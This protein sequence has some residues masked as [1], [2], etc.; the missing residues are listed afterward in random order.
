MRAEVTKRTR[1]AEESGSM[2]I[3]LMA[4]IVAAGLMV[5][6]T[7]YALS[8]HRTVRFDRNRNTVIQTADA[9]INQVLF[10]L[11]S[12]QSVPTTGSFSAW[13]PVSGPNGAACTSL[14]QDNCFRWRAEPWPNASGTD[15][16]ITSEGTLNGVT[17]RVQAVLNRPQP[18]RYGVFADN[19]LT[20]N[21]GN[22]VN[23][24]NATTW[25]TG[26][27]EL[28]SNGIVRLNGAN[29]TADGVDIHNMDLA[30]TDRCIQNGNSLCTTV[31]EDFAPAVDLTSPDALAFIANGL[32]ACTTNLGVWRGTAPLNGGV[33]C[34]ERIEIAE[35][36]NVVVNATPA[37]PAIIYLTGP[38][39][40]TAHTV[41]VGRG[42]LVNCPTLSNGLCTTREA[43]RLQIFT[44]SALDVRIGNH[45]HFVGTI[46]APRASCRGNPSNAQAHFYGSLVC[47]TVTNQGGWNFHYDQRLST[48]SVGDHRV[49]RWS[50]G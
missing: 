17:R 27:G 18:F 34:A 45:S 43:Q 2:V 21:G 13:Q 6:I 14:A 25:G 8:G 41:S 36:A 23:S 40:A 31:R 39:T 3:A 29:V 38:P 24:Y 7:S 44:A 37:N 15:V 12:G 26:V 20:F 48:T 28:G 1:F 16:K 10:M 42:A 50:E 47:R 32:A 33:Y 9:G 19:R 5:V 35:K 46:Y 49:T 4:S 22:S 11:Q 30:P